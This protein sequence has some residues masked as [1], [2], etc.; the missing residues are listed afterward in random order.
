MI[1]DSDNEDSP[2]DQ[3]NPPVNDDPD[4]PPMPSD[5]PDD[6]PVPSDDLQL[7]TP[8][9]N[10]VSVHQFWR[11]F[12]I[13]D[14]IDHLILAWRDINEATMQRSWKKLTPH[15][16]DNVAQ[17][18]EVARQVPGFEAVS[19]EDIQKINA[20][21]EEQT[22]EKVVDTLNVEDEIEEQ[23]EA[24]TG[25]IQ[26]E[27]EGEVPMNGLSDILAKA[28]ALKHSIMMFEPSKMKQIEFCLQL[29]SIIRH[30]NELHNIKVNKR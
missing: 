1:L 24:G 14:A 6:P 27:M 22:P 26:Q 5:D 21:G 11:Q 13:K 30:Y 18:V 10:A 28:E 16:A 15:L 29:S 23:V 12:N 17:V 3:P 25:C 4:D 20:L 2:V 19:A 9:C 7:Q 8:N